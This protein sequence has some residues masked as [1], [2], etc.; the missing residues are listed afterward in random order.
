M[1]SPGSEKIDCR[2]HT[3]DKHTEQGGHG[4]LAVFSTYAPAFGAQKPLAARPPC[5]A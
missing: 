1:D 5:T 2:C 3:A 4:R